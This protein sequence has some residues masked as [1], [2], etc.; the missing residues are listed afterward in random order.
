MARIS[1]S[2]KVSTNAVKS[3][4][5]YHI[6]VLQFCIVLAGFFVYYRRADPLPFIQCLVSLLTFKLTTL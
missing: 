2:E 6:L 1:S 5:V 4:S 3:F